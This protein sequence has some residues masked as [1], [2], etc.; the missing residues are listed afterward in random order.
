VTTLKSHFTGTACKYLSAVDATGTSNQHEIGSNK[1]TQILGNP[2]DQ[3]RRFTATFLYFQ[4]DVDEPVCCTGEVTYYD[5]RLNQPNRSAEYRLY[6]KDNAVTQEMDAGDFCLVGIRT[7]GELLIA[8]AKPGSEAESR[9]RYLF[10]VEQ[11]NE[12]W[13]IEDGLSDATLDFASRCILSALEIEP[14]DDA[15]DHV[16]ELVRKFGSA[17]PKTKEF[18]TY[19]RAT[20][21]KHVSGRD[22]PDAALE[23]WMTQEERLF[24]ALEKTI[25]GKRLETGFD[26]VDDFVAFSLSVHNRRKARVGH[27]LEHH[28]EAAFIASGISY[29]RGVRTEGHARPDFLF[30]GAAQYHDSRIGS[31]PLRMLAA[32]ST[33]KDRWRQILAEA[34]RIPQ[35]HLFTLETAIS[36]NQTDEMRAHQVQLVVPPSVARTYTAAQQKWAISLRDFI[37]LLPQTP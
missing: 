18:S 34:Q 21:G 4:P 7:N 2:G 25:V 14:Q 31:P 30:P 12:Q 35:K 33:C 26:S 20:L 24:R 15:L 16:D 6:Y 22:D 8:V 23:A 17:F 1:F 11:A 19:A 36:S 28:L 5:T 29:A 10:G 32:K 13:S 27:A 9:L 3:K 37:D